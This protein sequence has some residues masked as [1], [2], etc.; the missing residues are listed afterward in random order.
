MK[1]KKEEGGIKINNQLNKI[2]EHSN[3]IKDK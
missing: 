1:K 2:M 3:K